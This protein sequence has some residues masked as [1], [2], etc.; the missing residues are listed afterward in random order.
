MAVCSMASLCLFNRH[1]DGV[2]RVLYVHYNSVAVT[3]MMNAAVCE[4]RAN[5]YSVLLLLL[6]LPYC[7]S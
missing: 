7:R 3:V 6:P 1:D 2:R 4:M 5:V